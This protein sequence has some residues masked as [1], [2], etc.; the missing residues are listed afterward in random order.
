ML[1]GEAGAETEL[2]VRFP[3]PL[4]VTV[5]FCVPDEPLKIL[6]KST[7]AGETF[8]TGRVEPVPESNTVNAGVTGSFEST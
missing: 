6:P 1:K 2:I 3:E 4:L 7:V 5:M 8:M